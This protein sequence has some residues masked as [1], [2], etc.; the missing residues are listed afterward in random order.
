PPATAAGAQAAAPPAALAVPP[1]EVPAPLGP[2][3][4]REER[5]AAYQQFQRQG[6][7][8]EPPSGEW[9]VDDQGR[10]YYLYPLPRLEEGYSLMEDG[11]RVKLPYGLVMDVARMDEHNLF[12]KVYAPSP[13]VEYHLQR[14]RELEER[15]REL[16]RLFEVD[17]GTTERLAFER[18]D[19]GLPKRGQWRNGFA[20]A[21]L[22]GDGH[23]DLVHGPARKG[24]QRPTVFRGDGT[25]R[26]QPWQ[27][28]EFPPLPLDY[29][30][31]AVADFDGDGRLDLALAS[32]L[33]GLAVLVGRGD[34]GYE[35]WS[36]GIELTDPGAGAKPG[37]SSREIE[38][39][40]WNGDGRPDL[41]A[42]ADGPNLAMGA[43]SAEYQGGSRGIAVY[44]NNGD[45]T[46][47][48]E[49]PDLGIDRVY[50]DS[51]EVGDLDGDG[52][53]DL[54]IAASRRG[55]KELV[56]R[57]VAGGGVEPVALT[58]LP[59]DTQVG[60]V[61]IA[62]FDGD[63]RPDLAL[64]YVNNLLGTWL[65]GLD[66]LLNRADGWQRRVL[67]AEEARDGVWSLG[68]GDLDADGRADLVALR[69]SGEAMVFL[70]DGRGGF[71]R[72]A[73]EALEP[74]GYQCRGYE[75]RLVDLDGEPGDEILAG[76]AG[77]QGS[78]QLISALRAAQG[79]RHCPGGGG[80]SGWKAVPR[81]AAAEGGDDLAADR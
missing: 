3:A 79:Q 38:A 54:V 23:L 74:P 15:R 18:F 30:D 34:G 63:G 48:P 14:Q 52:R 76:Y 29:G 27:E 45:G 8:M 2:E 31:V 77:E 7:P 39:V 57:G 53:N 22:D 6:A 16:A 72:H 19:A 4:T 56:F 59:D 10:R 66:V 43:G 81:G 47:Q 68:S 32:H 40:D 26:W 73:A 50:G 20:V 64:G 5:I 33:R 60:A 11:Q 21:D 78:E 17:A 58:E 24:G 80:L 9:L 46:W 12:L 61:E 70:G 44:L 25:G 37:F 41:V 35:P 13:E 49:R 75:V 69:G 62:D 65:T 28:A 67:A 55:L 51:L 1:A 42:L 36:E 71:A